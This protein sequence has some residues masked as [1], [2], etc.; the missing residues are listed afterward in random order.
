MSRPLTA[1][2]AALCIALTPSAVLTEAA[3]AG[4]G[5]YNLPSLGTVA[6]ADL[7]VLDERALGQELM[8][9]VRADASY[10]NDPET[11]DYLNRLGLRLVAAGE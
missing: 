7:T 1:L 2:A 8:R 3:V 5:Q 6:G 11:T 10:M 4:S 9:R